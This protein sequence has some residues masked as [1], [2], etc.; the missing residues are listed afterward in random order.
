M[1]LLLSEADVKNILTMPMAL[2]AVEDSFRR[3]A[4]G[5]AQVHSRQRLH[6]PGR[7]YLHYMAAADAVSGYMGL[8][9]YTSARE[10]L[11]FLVPLFDAQSGDLVA[12]DRS[13]L[14]GP[15]AHR[16]GQRR[17]N[18][19]D[20]SSGREHGGNHRHGIAGADAIGS[21]RGSCGKYERYARSAAPRSIASNSRR[22]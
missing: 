3:L 19:P 4:D 5:S 12:L 11:R 14:P 10:G 13:G 21:D 18:S 17:G 7:S 15:N 9:M 16:R 6:I 8:K 1:A 22:Q 20:G 2:E